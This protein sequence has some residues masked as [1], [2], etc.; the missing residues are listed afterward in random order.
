M[1]RFVVLALTGMLCVA[2]KVGDGE[3]DDGDDDSS[4]FEDDPFADDPGD[5]DGDTGDD[6]PTD[7]DAGMGMPDD[8]GDSNAIGGPVPSDVLSGTKPDDPPDNSDATSAGLHGLNT[9]TE[10]EGDS[11]DD[12]WNISVDLNEDG[13]DDVVVVVFDDETGDLYFEYKTV[14]EDWCIDGSDGNADVLEVYYETRSVDVVLWET[15]CEE[16]AGIIFGCDLDS[17]GDIT[18]NCGT[19]S[20][21]D[22][23][24]IC[25]EDADAG[26]GG[27]DG[28]GG[29]GDSMVDPDDPDRCSI[30]DSPDLAG[31]NLSMCDLAMSELS[32]ADLSDA[33]L[34][35]ITLTQANLAGA[36][37]GRSDLTGANLADVD[38]TDAN[39]DD[40]IF[41]DAVMTDAIMTE[42]FAW[43]ADFD[44]AD[45]QGA[46]MNN[47]DLSF[48]LMRDTNLRNASM[49]GAMLTDV[50]WGNTT[51][52]DGTN[53][54]NNSGSTCEGHL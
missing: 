50:A 41:Q 1:L 33:D 49:S 23:V 26:P 48:S 45:L 3:F 37:L 47:A 24:W 18:D 6:P 7:P 5:G 36:D 12:Q 35:G 27:N 19:C 42:A 44:G 25:E 31:R 39:I 21:S 2:C 10:Q 40:A 9:D 46:N 52:P 14:I 11:G 34:T 4:I 30:A 38:L 16:D 54:D 13:E 32:F 17:N 29:D 43:R 20:Q 8:S 51:C 15:D 22:G 53:S 28:D